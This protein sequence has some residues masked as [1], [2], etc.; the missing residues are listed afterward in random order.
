MLLCNDVSH[1]LGVSLES[2]LFKVSWV[3]I[4]N[5]HTALQKLNKLWSS[6]IKRKTHIVASGA[7]SSHLY[8]RGLNQHGY[9]LYGGEHVSVHSLNAN[10]VR[11]A[12]WPGITEIHYKGWNE[13][14]YPFPNVNVCAVEVWEWISHFIPHFTYD[15][16]SSLWLTLIH[17]SKGGPRISTTTKRQTDRCFPRERIWNT[18]AISALRNDRK[19]RYLCFQ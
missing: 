2:A 10:Y 15:Y 14:T 16:S 3:T 13:R 6:G 18:Y 1:W 19:Y 17:V 11:I 8:K 7:P 5:G 4:R 9:Y 12:Y